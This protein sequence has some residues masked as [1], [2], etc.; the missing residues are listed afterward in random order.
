MI[1]L[2]R[3]TVP[4]ARRYSLHTS[5]ASSTST[6]FGMCAASDAPSFTY[7][8]L[9]LGLG[10]AGVE[11]RGDVHPR[12]QQAHNC[13]DP[14]RLLGLGSCRPVTQSQPPP[15]ALFCVGTGGVAG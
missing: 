13:S 5:L 1:G 2:M 12:R 11:L 14:G 15:R 7:S 9:P 10:R 4:S 3:N 6:S 8:S